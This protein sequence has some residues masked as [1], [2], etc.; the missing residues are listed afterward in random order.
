MGWYKGRDKFRSEI[1]NNK[2]SGYKECKYD[3][4][5]IKTTI[6]VCKIMG[7]VSFLKYYYL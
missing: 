5:T 2:N 6:L 3:K 4:A 7:G 1:L